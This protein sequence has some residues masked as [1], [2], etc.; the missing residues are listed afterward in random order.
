MKK[1]IYQLIIWIGRSG[2]LLQQGQIKSV[3]S[4]Q[5]PDVAAFATADRS[6]PGDAYMPRSRLQFYGSRYIIINDIRE[7][8]LSSDRQRRHGCQYSW[9]FYGLRMVTSYINILECGLCQYQPG[10]L[11]S[12]EG[13]RW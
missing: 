8:I 13:R 12:M 11:S 10:N 7:V 5:L 9:N 3:S 2:K 6:A 4:T 1:Y